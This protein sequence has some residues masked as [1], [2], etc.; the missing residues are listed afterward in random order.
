M[1]TLQRVGLALSQD[2]TVILMATTGTSAASIL[3]KVKRIIEHTP[4]LEIRV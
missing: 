3:Q 1:Q 2:K 4:H